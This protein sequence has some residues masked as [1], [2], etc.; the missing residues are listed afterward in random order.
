MEF[1]RFESDRYPEE[2]G[3]YLM[4]DQ[5]GQLL[6]VG[7]AKNL[8]RRL[9][10]YFHSRPDRIKVAHLVQEIADI[11]IMIVRNENE[12]LALETNLIQYYLPP[13]NRA[14]K[15]YLSVH[16]YIAVT[17]ERLP[18]L[19]AIDQERQAPVKSRLDDEVQLIGPFPNP[20][21]RQYAL[22]FAIDRYRLRTCQPLE[23]RLC[24]RYYFGKCGGICE[25]KETEEQY[26]NRFEDALR[27][28]SEPKSIALEMAEMV[29]LLCE[30][31]QFEKAKE[32]HT[33]LNAIRS[34]LDKQAVN[35]PQN[36]QQIAVFFGTN[37]L[38]AA[39]IEYGMLRSRFEMLATN[40]REW[41]EKLG[42]ILP[43][44]GRLEIITNDTEQASP[45]LQNARSRRLSVKVTVP[46]KGTKL[47]MLNICERNFV[48]R[49][50]DMARFEH[51]PHH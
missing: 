10:S 15:R 18:R 22:E 24:M 39:R 27:L 49:M 28:L 8:R 23:K 4:F 46:L 31:L 17:A 7:K 37:H 2:P 21:F 20:I 6:Y 9:S 43:N 50:A 13:Y 36:H 5:G 30:R 26:D 29:E 51:I 42:F 11:E 25:G 47:H 1:F 44:S 16:P 40:C 3:C 35:V 32:L 34:M 19:L 41:V 45:I 12:S 48:Y 33:R 38:L 14:K